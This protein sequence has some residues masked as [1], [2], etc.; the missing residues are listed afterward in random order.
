MLPTL[1]VEGTRQG[2]AAK[3]AV[4]LCC[5]CGQVSVYDTMISRQS[6][7]ICVGR[8]GGSVGGEGVAGLT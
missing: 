6:G 5:C 3:R 1:Q 7:C 2:P 8:P 4:P